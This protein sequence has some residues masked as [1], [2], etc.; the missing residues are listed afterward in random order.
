M[1]AEDLWVEVP[2]GRIRIRLHAL[3]ET[4]LTLLLFGGN[5]ESAADYDGT[6]ALFAAF[7]VRLAVADYRGYGQSEGCPSLRRALAD[8]ETAFEALRNLL[9]GPVG[10]MG[11]SLGSQCAA[12]LAPRADLACLVWE[13]GFL[14]LQD[15]MARR[16][17]EVT[18]S[19]PEADRTA[20]DPAPRLF[21]GHA[22][23]LVLHAEEDMVID[24]QEALH[25]FRG[26]PQHR[27]SLVFIPERGHNDIATSPLYWQAL[28]IFFERCCLLAGPMTKYPRQ[29][30]GLY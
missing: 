2:E 17:M 18:D 22:P 30:R 1:G 15:L 24:P 13:S 16:G 20:F 4:N 25:A 26:Y 7:G 29:S 14:D 6:G 11:R 27:K 9:P 23:L 3:G 10:V 21:A 8:A 12:V 5:G 19:F 28:K